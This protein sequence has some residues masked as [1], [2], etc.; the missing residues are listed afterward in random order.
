MIRCNP[1]LYV[2]KN[3]L[4]SFVLKCMFHIA[5]RSNNRSGSWCSGIYY[6]IWCLNIYWHYVLSLII[7]TCISVYILR[8]CYTSFII[9]RLSTSLPYSH[10]SCYL[11]YWFGELP[12]LVL[13]LQKASCSI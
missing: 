4:L 12:F 6:A 13:D 9:F 1:Q 11:F 2:K 10:T 5:R 7:F 3:S 8:L